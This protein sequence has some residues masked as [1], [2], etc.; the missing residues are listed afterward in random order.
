MKEFRYFYPATGKTLDRLRWMQNSLPCIVTIHR[1]TED[2]ML[3]ASVFC[4]GAT[5]EIVQK[6]IEKLLGTP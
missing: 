6:E 5:C 4:M 3:E 2:H 1:M